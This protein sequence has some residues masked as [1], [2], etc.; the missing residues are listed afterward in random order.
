[1]VA[2]VWFLFPS[3]YLCHVYVRNDNL[4]AVVIADAEYPQRVCFTLLE[5]VG[6]KTCQQRS[7][8]ITGTLLSASILRFLFVFSGTRGILQD[9]GQ[10]R[11]ALW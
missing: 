10:Y 1:M 4:G 9:S 6:T 5:K 11:L 7:N 3:E 8:I 2:R